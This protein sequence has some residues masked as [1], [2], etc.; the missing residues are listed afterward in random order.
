MLHVFM[1]NI[2]M[3]NLNNTTV[4]TL[5]DSGEECVL[6]ISSKSKRREKREREREVL[7]LY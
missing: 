1:K 6:P 7:K 2:T 4:V 5:N 3:R